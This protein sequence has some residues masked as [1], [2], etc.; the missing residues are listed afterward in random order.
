MGLSLVTVEAIPVLEYLL[1][2]LTG[3]RLLNTVH[4]LKVA[5]IYSPYN[6]RSADRTHNPFLGRVT[7]NKYAI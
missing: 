6:Y 2:E 3:Y 1:A 4:G 5:S 7:P